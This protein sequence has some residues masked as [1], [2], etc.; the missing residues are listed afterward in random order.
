MPDQAADL[1]GGDPNGLSICAVKHS[2][3][4]ESLGAT[5]VPEMDPNDVLHHMFVFSV[6]FA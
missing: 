4:L 6:K 2:P 3:R 5:L 1:G